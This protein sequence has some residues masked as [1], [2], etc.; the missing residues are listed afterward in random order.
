MADLRQT[1]ARWARHRARAWDAFLVACLVVVSSVASPASGV[2]VGASGWGWPLDPA[3][4]AEPFTAPAHRYGT[5]HRG[6]D[7][8]ATVG[9]EV[10]APAAGV[11]AFAGVVVD[12][13]VLTI[14]HGAGYVSTLEPVNTVLVPGDRVE[15]GDVVGAIT[16][17]GHSAEG[18]LHVG[19]RLNGEYI[20]PLVLLGDIP[21][22]VLLPCC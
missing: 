11:V 4:V 6:V 16:T 13:G 9:A 18:Q 7:L 2:V 14:D 20:N 12:R 1:G 5:G 8:V 22:A 19:L 21:R 3:V 17:G 10:H 15:R